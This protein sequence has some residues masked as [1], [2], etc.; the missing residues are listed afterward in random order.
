M[1]KRQAPT[2]TA[3]LECRCRL[4]IYRTA[5]KYG[6]APV[7]ITAHVRSFHAD[8]ARKEVWREMI[9]KFRLRRWQVAHMFGRDVRRL[10]R[11]VIGV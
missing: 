10:R 7:L 6:I 3:D 9:G 5:E 1:S 8:K 4:L 11:S 2:I